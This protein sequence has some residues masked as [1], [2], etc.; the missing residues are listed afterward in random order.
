M[1]RY[2]I[3]KILPKHLGLGSS[4]S[5]SQLG[6]NYHD[7]PEGDSLD[8]SV[9]LDNLYP[10]IVQCF[11]V[12]LCG[13]TAGRLGVISNSEVKGL[14]TFVGTFALPAVIFTSLVRLDLSSVNWTFI[15]GVFL[16]KAAVFFSVLGVTYLLPGSLNTARA[17]LYAIFTTQTNDYALG[18][19]IVKALYEKVHPEFLPYLYLLAPVNLTIL[20]PFGFIF[21][22]LHKS[23]CRA[24]GSPESNSY[25]ALNVLRNIVTNPIVFMSMLGMACNFIFHHEPPDLLF[26]ILDVFSSAFSATALF[27]LGLRMVGKVQTLHGTA[28]IVPGVLIGVK[29]VIVPLVLRQVVYALLTAFPDNSPTNGT[30]SVEAYSTFAFLYGTVPSAPGVFVYATSYNL[31]VELIASSMVACTFLSAPIMFVSARLISLTTLERKDYEGA[32]GKFNTDICVVSLFA[33]VWLVTS[34]LCQKNSRSRH[35]LNR[36]VNLLVI[37]R[38]CAILAYLSIQY[39][40]RPHHTPPGLVE[41]FINVFGDFST[42]VIIPCLALAVLLTVCHNFTLLVY[43]RPYF[44]ILYMGLPVFYYLVSSFIHS[45]PPPTS[46]PNDTSDPIELA[47][48]NLALFLALLVTVVCL[49]LTQRQNR[50]MSYSPMVMGNSQ[51]E[52]TRETAALAPNIVVNDVHDLSSTSQT[53]DMVNETDDTADKEES[54]LQHVILLILLCISMFISLACGLWYLELGEGFVGNIFVEMYFVE[55][56]LRLGMPLIIFCVFAMDTKNVFSPAINRIIEIYNKEDR[57]QLVP[58]DQLS[59]ETRH[60]CDQFIG[61]HLRQC[62]TDIAR[63]IRWKLLLY[64]QCFTGEQFISWLLAHNIAQDRGRGLEYAQHLVQGRVIR[65]IQG[66]YAFQDS[67]HKLYTFVPSANCTRR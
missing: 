2:R 44:Y 47:V 55:N 66:A 48:Q 56:A 26:K 33:C 43:L 45:P 16:A 37:S 1:L 28:L 41:R 49:V 61:Y 30:A 53:V 42:L 34:F 5:L 63:D 21:L 51:A 36:L 19:P 50:A 10:A 11:A 32:L 25:I 13:Y 35:L 14:N 46:D 40:D 20:N 65:H 15:A 29:L 12:I 64:K 4:S 52:T 67:R 24:A 38:I 58:W 54:V 31:D 9:E 60:V 23:R 18:V 57:I 22:E 59:F 62:R 7:F 27:L 6:M 3:F 17:G 8:T 39:L